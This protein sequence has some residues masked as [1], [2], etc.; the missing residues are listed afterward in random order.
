VGAVFTI[1]LLSLQLL[2][3]AFHQNRHRGRSNQEE[4]IEDYRR[5][6]AEYSPWLKTVQAVQQWLPPGLAARSIEQSGTTGAAPALGSLS[7]LGLYALAAAAA[8][9]TRLRAEYRGENLGQAP[10]R[11][12][13]A[14]RQSKTSPARVTAARRESAG[15]SRGSGVIAAVIEK[16]LRNLMRTLPLLWALGLPVLMVLILAGVFHSGS[17]GAVNPFQFALPLCVAYA[18]LGFTQ[19]F[20]NNMGTEGAGIQLLFLSP[21]PIRTVFLAKNLFHGMLFCLDALLAAT[22]TTLRLGQSSGEIVTATA[23]WLLFA[24]P[25]NLAAGNILSLTMPYRINPGRISRQRGSQASA[26]LSLLIQVV[27]MGVGA[28]VFLLSWYLDDPWM[29]VP[30]FVAL[31]GVAFFVWARVLANVDGIANRRRETL[32]SALMKSS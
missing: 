27:V 20:Y 21:T 12:K 13:A 25:C 7:L 28:A 11:D 4:R 17:S 8:L 31:A 16:D 32:I 24:L 30:I 3:P 14:A 2:N 23:A 26:M 9:G 15:R 18:L 10:R 5:M 19:F 29:A 22:L 6:K 1:L